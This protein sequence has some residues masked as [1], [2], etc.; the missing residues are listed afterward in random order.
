MAEHAGGLSSSTKAVINQNSVIQGLKYELKVME[1]RLE[2]ARENAEN[3]KHSSD[4]QEDERKTSTN[5]MRTQESVINGLRLELRIM[6]N[7]LSEAQDELRQLRADCS[8]YLSHILVLEGKA[9]GLPTKIV[10]PEK[11]SQSTPCTPTGSSTFEND[12]NEQTKTPQ[13][14]SRQESQTSANKTPSKEEE[15]DLSQSTKAVITQAAVINGLKLEIKILSNRLTDAQLARDALST[16]IESYAARMADYEESAKAH[17]KELESLVKERDDAL[18]RF[19]SLEDSVHVK[20]KEGDKESILL[21]EINRVSAA[22][23]S[24]EAEKA[25][26]EEDAKHSK[27][28]S[29]NAIMNQEAVIAGLKYE[30]DMLSDRLSH[31]DMEIIRL[32]QE[33]EANLA[34]IKDGEERAN[35]HSLELEKLVKERDSAFARTA[36]A[37]AL[38]SKYQS[39]KEADSIMLDFFR[40]SI[41]QYRTNEGETNQQLKTLQATNEDLVAKLASYGHIATPT[42]VKFTPPVASSTYTASATTEV[43]KSVVNGQ[44][45]SPKHGQLEEYKVQL[46]AL[47][48]KYDKLHGDLELEDTASREV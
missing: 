3:I 13:S 44:I 29:Q 6:E 45:S 11:Q 35:L 27:E 16:D 33:S 14:P 12:M 7:R 38:A 5:A 26:V 30:I 8:K 2:E 31:A 21:V 46:E 32:R 18:A 47:K 25:R 23:K 15:D 28:R 39:E 48:F 1:E 19:N 10:T 24:C 41:D 9:E 40:R 42:V 34:K 22:L 36:E 4:S 43:G 17:S 20:A 37:E